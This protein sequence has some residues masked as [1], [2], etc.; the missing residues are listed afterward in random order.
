[1]GTLVCVTIDQ[2]S[3]SYCF[4]NFFR[5]LAEINVYFL[6]MEND[7]RL[8][9]SKNKFIKKNKKLLGSAGI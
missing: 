1:M 9:F 8:G 3:T 6:I 4:W 7:I 5:R 2:R